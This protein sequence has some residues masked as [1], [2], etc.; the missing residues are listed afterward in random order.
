MPASYADGIQ[1]ASKAPPNPPPAFSYFFSSGVFE[2][3]IT[4]ATTT[5]LAISR[6]IATVTRYPSTSPTSPG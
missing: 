6:R 1:I 2:Y 4:T 5:A 3:A